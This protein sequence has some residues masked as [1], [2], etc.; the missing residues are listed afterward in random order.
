MKPITIEW[1]RVALSDGPLD[2]YVARLV[3][4]H[5]TSA[6]AT[7]YCQGGRWRIVW[8]PNVNSDGVRSFEVSTREKGVERVERW[9]K[10]HGWN[11]P[12][13]PYPGRSALYA[14]DTRPL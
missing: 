13:Q 1:E 10:H 6:F 8:Y 2:L 9:A 7:L 4:P 5:S 12:E 3:E 14:Y 11:L